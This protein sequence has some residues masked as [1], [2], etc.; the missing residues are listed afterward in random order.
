MLRRRQSKRGQPQGRPSDTAPRRPG[1]A[2]PC[3]CRSLPHTHL[4]PLG[5]PGVEVDRAD[6]GDV[7]AQAAV[8]ARAADAQEDAEVP[9]RPARPCRG[10]AVEGG[11]GGGEGGL[12]VGAL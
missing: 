1:P 8:D 6:F 3:P 9:R 2:D 5:G 12:A 4:N 11:G 7:D 10:G